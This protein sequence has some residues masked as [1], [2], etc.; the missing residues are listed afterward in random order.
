VLICNF[1]KLIENG[2]KSRNAWIFLID[3]ETEEE[4]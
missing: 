1:E 4:K 3:F 2:K